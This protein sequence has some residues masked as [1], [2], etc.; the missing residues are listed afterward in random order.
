MNPS[1]DILGIV[2][3]LQDWWKELESKDWPPDATEDLDGEISNHFPSIA[4][5]LLIAND[6]L[7]EISTGGRIYR[8]LTRDELIAKA[9]EARARIRSLPLQ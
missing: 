8:G 4:Q 3:E 5:A 1:Q 6:V 9:K 2:K 7:D